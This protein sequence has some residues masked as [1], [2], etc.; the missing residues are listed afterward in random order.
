MHKPTLL[1]RL[2]NLLKQKKNNEFYSKRLGISVKE[3][4]DLRKE[5]RQVGQERAETA[6]YISALEERVVEADLEKGTL[7]STLLIDF[8]PKSVEELYD[9]HKV[10]KSLYKIVNYWSKLKSNGKFTSSVF[11]TSRKP[12]DYTVEDFANWL[13]G[14]NPEPLKVETFEKDH[15]IPEV[16]IEIS[17]A[18]FHLAKKTIQNETIGGR[19]ITYLTVLARLV[20]KVARSF[21]INKVVFVISN[22][23]FHSD[24]YHGTT[25][26]GT[27]QDVSTEYDHEYEVGFDLLAAAIT[28]LKSMSKEVEVVL[29]QGNH[30]R[31]KSFYVAHALEV[32]F[33]EDKNIRF[34]R[35]DSTVK[36]VVLGNTFIGYHHGNCKIEDLP[37]LFATG[38][39]AADFG[40]SQFREVHTGD[41]HF[42]MAKEIKGVR[43]Q[44]M[45]SLSGTDR[46]HRDNNYVNSI[47]AALV[48]I[49]DQQLGKIGEFEERI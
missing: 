14:Y 17:I 25:T 21:N 27:P 4:E 43:I 19:K 1:D 7:K 28:Y 11:A 39:T 33:K 12:E 42:Y 34:Q 49:Y 23:F 37:L 2:R 40:N 41:K 20:E 47:R 38:P 16:D 46:W 6:A 45:P 31:T 26:N 13:V 30:D 8:E 36:H 48:L 9:L 10:D 5:L 32:Y 18:D 24:N 44:Q 3:V 22:D 35:H 15:W 29:V